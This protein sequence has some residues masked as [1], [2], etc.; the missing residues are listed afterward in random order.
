MNYIYAVLD[1]PKYTL[2][3]FMSTRVVSSEQVCRIISDVV[4]GI[5]FLKKE[6]NDVDRIKE[7]MIFIEEEE[8]GDIHAKIMNPFFK[9][10][11][12]EGE[13]AKGP[14]VDLGS[15]FKKYINPNLHN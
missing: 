12:Y 1:K 4:K 10:C 11:G 9:D 2:S 5:S 13:E 14:V 7:D 8:N 6:D 3:S 15:I